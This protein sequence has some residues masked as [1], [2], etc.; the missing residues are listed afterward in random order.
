MKKIKIVFAAALA[1]LALGA[2]QVQAQ[3]KPVTFGIKAGANLSTLGGDLDDSKSVFK[4]QFGITADIALTDN[5]YLLTGLDFQ[6]KGAEFKVAEGAKVEYNPI[7][8]QLPATLGYKFDLGS[9]TRLVLNAGPYLAYGI[10]G[11]AK[12]A[13]EDLKLFNDEILKRF[14][15]GVIGGV[16]VEFGRIAVGAGYDL[17]LGNISD[18]TGTKVRNRNAYLTVGYK[19]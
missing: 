2:A 14:D 13:G 1:V 10:G 15:Y 5:L 6:A 4:Y 12:G 16:G 7:Y 8:L 18:V 9:D 3:D 11:K 19:F 17:G